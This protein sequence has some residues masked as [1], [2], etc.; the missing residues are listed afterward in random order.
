MLLDT[1]FFFFI[2][3]ERFGL[4]CHLAT[5]TTRRCCW[6][7]RTLIELSGGEDGERLETEEQK[8][9]M[10]GNLTTTAQTKRKL[11]GAIFQN[12][13]RSESLTFIFFNP[14]KSSPF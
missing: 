2:F 9:A 12:K 5:V 1:D 6:P 11:L 3:L 4:Y 14:S 7:I 8:L 10:P 13:I